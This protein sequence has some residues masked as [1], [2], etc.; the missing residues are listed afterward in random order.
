MTTIVWMVLVYGAALWW[1]L[2]WFVLFVNLCGALIQPFIQRRRLPQQPPGFCPPVSV[3]APIK[4]LDPGFE[5]AFGSLFGL[6]YPDYEILVGAAEAD[7]PALQAAQTIAARHETRACRFLQSESTEA[8]SPKLNVLSRPLAE[9]R[10]DFILTKDSN[11][12]FTPDT[13][14]ALMRMVT[15]DIGLVVMVPV[16]VRAKSLAGEIEAFLINGHARL[17][18]TASAFGQGFGVGKVMLFRRSDL[19]KAGGFASISHSLAEDSALSK[20]LAAIGLRT[21]FAPITVEQETGARGFRD[22]YER[23]SRWAII[24]RKEEPAS[25][26]LEPLSSPLPAA[27]AAIPAASLLGLSGGFGFGMTLLVWFVL[28]V[29]CAKIKGWE[30]S[31]WT[32]LAFLGREILALAAWL[33]AWTTHDVVW[34]Q[35]RYD[36]RHGARA[37]TPKTQSDGIKPKL[38]IKI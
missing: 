5:R 18:L 2:S 16:A 23:Q 19:A 27:L 29:L 34:A 7:S 1:V 37:A 25:F 8:V 6:D 32:P 24:R 4:L 20:G 26:P 21:V 35:G 22:I 14:R 11:I 28:E 10:H 30:V 15:P 33:R 36:A 3:I 38:G 12:T 13:L 31:A 9:A 17:L